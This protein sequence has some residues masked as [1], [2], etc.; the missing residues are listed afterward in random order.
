M[1]LVQQVNNYGID[2]WACRTGVW[3]NPNGSLFRGS[4]Q[5]P[6]Y[7]A[8][9]GYVLTGSKNK[10]EGIQFHFVVFEILIILI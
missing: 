3:G 2:F 1:D 5:S 10:F 4:H 6:Q 7:V 9:Y 8:G